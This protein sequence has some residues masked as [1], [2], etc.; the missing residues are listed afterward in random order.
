MTL[1]TRTLGLPLLNY[2]ASLMSCMSQ[3]KQMSQ[4]L[5]RT[6]VHSSPKSRLRCSYAPVAQRFCKPRNRPHLAADPAHVVANFAANGSVLPS[7]VGIR[8][9]PELLPMLAS[10][11]RAQSLRLAGQYGQQEFVKFDAYPSFKAEICT[12]LGTAVPAL[13][14]SSLPLQANISIDSQGNV[15]H[16]L[17]HAVGRAIWR[18]IAGAFPTDH[19]FD[20]VQ[21]VL[22]VPPRRSLIKQTQE[23]LELESCTEEIELL[24]PI[25]VLAASESNAAEYKAALEGAAANPSTL[26]L[27]IHDECHWGMLKESVLSRQYMHLSESLADNVYVLHVSATPYNILAIPD[28]LQDQIIRWDDVARS[29]PALQGINSAYKGLAALLREGHFHPTSQR[30]IYDQLEL[31]MVATSKELEEAA[32]MVEYVLCAMEVVG[33]LPAGATQEFPETGDIF[34]SLVRAGPNGEGELTVLRMASTAGAECLQHWLRSILMAKRPDHFDVVADLGD[35]DERLW[36]KLSAESQRRYKQ[37]R[38]LTNLS[39]VEQKTF[40]FGDLKLLPMLLMVVEKGRFGDTFPSNFCHFDL[41]PRY[42]SVAVSYA[43]IIQ[44]VGLGFQILLNMSYWYIWARR[45]ALSGFWGYI[46]GGLREGD[47]KFNPQQSTGFKMAKRWSERLELR[48][49]SR[50]GAPLCQARANTFD[51]DAHD[52]ALPGEPPS[53]PMVERALSALIINHCSIHD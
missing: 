49:A 53:S 12:L 5:L 11:L 22:L 48:S 38:N 19:A 17:Q 8:A 24:G 14:R 13:P 42:S 25:K 32:I 1:S 41:R 2:A 27:V 35:A 39:N 15:P 6:S 21:V 30:I 44:D 16:E 43:S 33:I 34:R 40:S 45:R 28:F 29:E 10:W 51:L 46:S 9:P 3:M 37:W 50:R 47:A 18:A 31:S 52:G 20:M 7:E 26:Y 36:G 23:R 4:Q